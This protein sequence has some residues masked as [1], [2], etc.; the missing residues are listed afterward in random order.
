LPTLDI[1]PETHELVLLEKMLSKENRREYIFK[2]KLIPKLKNYDVII[3]DN[4]PSWNYLIENALT[5]SDV[6]I[7]PLG[8]NLLSYNASGTNFGS[9][10]E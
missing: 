1:I 4:G 6:I 10:L 5:T 2:D 3:F 8:C 9:I 7:C